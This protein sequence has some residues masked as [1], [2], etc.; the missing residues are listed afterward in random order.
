MPERQ[1]AVVTGASSGIGKWI[2]L[3]LARRGM[4]LVLVARDAGRGQAAQDW[5]ADQTTGATTEL[6][7]ADL[8]LLGQV[9]A[10]GERIAAAHPRIA[11][12]VNNAGLFS[13]RRVLTVEG[14]ELT[15][16]VNHLAPFMLTRILESALRAGTPARVVNIGS[17]AS[18]R[19]RLELD[20]LEAARSYRMMEVYGRSKLAIMMATFE[21]ARRLDGSGVTVNV[22]HPGLVATRIGQVGGVTGLF[23]KL[24]APFML[25]PERGAE[26]PLHVALAPELARVSG[27]YFKRRQ[28]AR[29]NP[30]ALDRG[31]VTRLWAETERLVA[32]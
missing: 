28:E 6:V 7:L 23:W 25:R 10:A 18:D 9:H 14:H 20:D 4:H 31:A 32:L 12:L 30:Q 2:A 5:I 1:V 17:A 27:K 11:V 22:V 26:T 29:P 15:L 13:P 8:S 19:A 3:G 24:G 21:W 16:T